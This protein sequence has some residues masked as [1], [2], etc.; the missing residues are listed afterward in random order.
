MGDVKMTH[1]AFLCADTVILL[2]YNRF[3]E[4]KMTLVI[5]NA[6]TRL[7]NLINAINAFSSKP[8]TILKK[9][10]SYPRDLLDS[11]AEGEAEYREQKA[12]GNLKLYDS[13]EEAFSDL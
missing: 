4:A 7:Y 11:I 8:Y 13:A 9:N 12:S 1:L 6:D 10:D 2:W 5:P 3:E